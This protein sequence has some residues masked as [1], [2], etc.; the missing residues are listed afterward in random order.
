[1]DLPIEQASAETICRW[2]A[3]E[4]LLAKRT[5]EGQL[6]AL[7]KLRERYLLEPQHPAFAGFCAAWRSS[8]EDSQR[9]LLAYLLLGWQDGFFRTSACRWLAPLLRRPGTPLVPEA[10]GRF[11]DDLEAENP[12]VAQWGKTTR[13]RVCQHFLA[14]VRDFGLAAGKAKKVSVRPTVGPAVTWYCAHLSLLSG[15]CP[16]DALSGDWFTMLGLD[17]PEA[18]DA[19]YEMA[20]SGL[21]RFRVEGQVVDLELHQLR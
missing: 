5:R 12:S 21:G 2:I 3:D 1:M 11:I 19:L 15:L 14:A 9:A 4:N 10:F 18:M 13:V 8:D 17:L 16:R 20:A 6:K 7:R